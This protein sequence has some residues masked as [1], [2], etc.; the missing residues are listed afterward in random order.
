VALLL[1]VLKDLHHRVQ[2]IRGDGWQ[3][4]RATHGGSLD[5]LKLGVYGAGVIGLKFIEM[6]RPFG[7]VIKVFDPFLAEVPEGVTRVDSLDALFDDIQAVAIHAGWTPETD[8][9]VNARLL[10]KL[11]KHGVVINTARGGIVDQDALF[12]ELATG[13][14]RAGLDVF[15]PDY[16]PPGHPARKWE[17]LIVTSHSV[18]MS[19]PEQHERVGRMYE[20]ALDNLQR[21]VDGRPLRFVMDPVRYARST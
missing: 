16:L 6:V 2:L 14:L 17:N 18:A 4:D 13:R 10:A 11:P 8:K 19:W 9:S 1:A 15:E 20:Y 12:A 21:F 7:P 3:V 5:G